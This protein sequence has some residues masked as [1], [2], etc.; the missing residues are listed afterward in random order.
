MEEKASFVWK[1]QGGKRAEFLI[2]R[3]NQCKYLVRPAK[4]VGGILEE[5]Q[6]R[7]GVEG[8]KIWW[9]RMRVR[10]IKCME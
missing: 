10:A 4:V 8:M 7:H 1:L 6:W 9:N 2:E 5:A 3:I